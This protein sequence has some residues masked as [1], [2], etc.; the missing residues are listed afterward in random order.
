MNEHFINVKVDREER[1]DVDKVYMS[2]VQATTGGGGWPMSVF[3]TP[4]LKPIYGGT[5]FPPQD[6]VKPKSDILSFDNNGKEKSDI[7]QL[8]DFFYLIFQVFGR[9]GFKTI[10]RALSSKWEMQREQMMESGDRIIEALEAS[11]QTGVGTDDET[12][13]ECK[14]VVKTCFKQLSQSYD[15]EYGGFSKEPKFPQPVNFNF[16]FSFY[17]GNRNDDR[18]KQGLEMTLH[19][20][21]MMAKGGIHDHISQ[22]SKSLI[23]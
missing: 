11:K 23:F 9:P 7:G 8:S 2:F 17:A 20:L 13:P 22:V 19:T 4:K 18:A 21:K 10:L 1:P 3:L 15:S 6:S 5:Y 12:P 14:E 16:L